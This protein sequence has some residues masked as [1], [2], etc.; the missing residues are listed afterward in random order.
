MSA[1]VRPCT[2][3]LV[4]L[5]ILVCVSLPAGANSVTFNV[6]A[7]GYGYVGD[8]DDGLSVKAGIFSTFSAAPDGPSNLGFGAVG[9]PMNISFGPE[10]YPG[11]G[12]T[13]VSIGKQFTDILEGGIIFTS[14]TFT[15]PAS[16]LVT[17]T[18]TTPVD[19]VGQVMAF[20]DLG[21]QGVWIQ[22]P[23]M[24]S[25]SF[26]G[27]GTATFQIRGVGN[28]EFL[29]VSGEGSFKNIYGSLT[30]PTPEPSSLLLISTGLAA[31]GA[32]AGRSRGFLRRARL[33]FHG[34]TP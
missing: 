16:A 8:G 19:V 32:V 2:F 23:L 11:P 10:A 4:V 3:G 5:C 29:I 18:F 31:F 25:L 33:P 17:G 1:Y 27:T 20:Q 28:N 12:F 7:T 14:G 15:V 30:T 24:A 13:D 21:S 34:S 6:A 22:G 9:V 26:S